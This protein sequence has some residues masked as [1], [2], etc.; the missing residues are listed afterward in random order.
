MP[1]QIV[2]NLNVA[3]QAR[4]R[5]QMRRWRLLCPLLRLHILLLLAQQRSPT[6]IADWLLCSRSSVYETAAR[7]RQGW[8]P[9]SK[10]ETTETDPPLTLAASS[11]LVG[12]AGKTAQRLRLIPHA[13]ELCHFGLELT[14][15]TRHS[16]V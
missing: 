16:G 10:E 4:L 14:D 2:I 13:L 1:S 8:R 9:G 5:E 7:W 11:Q 6:E 3:E 12:L 15:A